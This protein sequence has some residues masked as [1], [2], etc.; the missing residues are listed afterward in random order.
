MTILTNIHKF[1]YYIK[2]LFDVNMELK[3][4]EYLSLSDSDNE[5]TT[6][7]ARNVGNCDLSSLRLV[8]RSFKNIFWRNLVVHNSSKFTVFRFDI[9]IGHS[10]LHSV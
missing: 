4:D 2:S 6:M 1:Q 3:F 8:I 10:L 9:T 7:N 5:K